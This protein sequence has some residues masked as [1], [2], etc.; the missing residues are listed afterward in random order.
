LATPFENFPRRIQNLILYGN[1]PRH[2]GAHGNTSDAVDEHKRSRG[3]K[4]APG[5]RFQ[6][7]FG[8]L[9]SNLLDTASDK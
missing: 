7:L 3:E 6:G 8:F 9:E 5:L 1:P 2:G 4:M